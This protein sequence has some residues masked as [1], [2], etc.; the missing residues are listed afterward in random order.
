MAASFAIVLAGRAPRPGRGPARRPASPS[1][2]RSAATPRSS[3]PP[4]SSAPVPARSPTRSRRSRCSGPWRSS[5]TRRSG[6]RSG[7]PSRRSGLWA[8]VAVHDT[9]QVIA[10]SAA[11]GPEALDVATVVKLIRN[12]LMAPLLFLI[13]SVWA[14]AAAGVDR[15]RVDAARRGV[16][17]RG[18]AVRP[19]VPRAGRAADGRRDR[20]GRR[21]R[22]STSWRGASSSS[23]SPASGCRSSVG[24]LRET[25]WRPLAVGFT[26]ALI[27]GLGSLVAI[28][29]LGLADGIDR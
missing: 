7:S 16:R 25:S 13:A 26:V 15:R 28:T 29:G 14:R 18:P 19:R 27:V 6:G 24:E 20:R 11:Y 4:R 10:T 1:G 2:R 17:P 21:R 3:R 23:R 12:A 22:P 5:S 9:S 8:G